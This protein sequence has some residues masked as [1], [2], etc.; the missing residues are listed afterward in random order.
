MLQLLAEQ[1]KDIGKPS[2]CSP[3]SASIL[4]SKKL[5]CCSPNYSVTA[6]ASTCVSVEPA[7]NPNVTGRLA[8]PSHS[9]GGGKI[10]TLSRKVLS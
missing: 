1:G 4:T 7:M 10:D 6:A 8:S 5:S 3:S 9:A 2:R